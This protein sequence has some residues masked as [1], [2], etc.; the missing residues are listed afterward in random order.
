[1][2]QSSPVT[3]T[4][5]LS[6]ILK[7]FDERLAQFED[8]KSHGGLTDLGRHAEL[9]VKNLRHEVEFCTRAVA[10]CS[11]EAVIEECAKVVEPKGPRPCDC[12][13]CYCGNH[14]DLEAVAAWDADAY[15]A[16]AIRAL[17]DSS[18]LSNSGA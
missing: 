16:K 7:I 12:E 3:E 8:I 9:V 11:R 1:M 14:G 2:T 10:P 15:N 5:L 17:A 4:V 13:R 6:D 18:T